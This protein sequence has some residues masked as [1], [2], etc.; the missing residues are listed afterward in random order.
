[1]DK[2]NI[3]GLLLIFALLFLWTRFNTPTEEQIKAEQIASAEE[4]LKIAQL[5]ADSLRT[6]N[7][8]LVENFELIEELEYLED[9]EIIENIDELELSV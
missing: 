2:K 3:I 1:M 5:N 7:I 6:E 8:E 9:L 4:E